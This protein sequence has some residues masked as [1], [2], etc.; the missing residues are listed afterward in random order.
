MAIID[1]F[2]R[3][4]RR[5]P[6]SVAY[7]CGAESWTFDEA[8]ELSCRISHALARAGCGR[9]VKA[10]VLSPND[11][12]AW[13]GVLGIWRAG[14]TWVPLNPTTPP[15][16]LRRVIDA[17]DCEVLFFH[18]STAS[19]VAELAPSLPKVRQYVC[20]DAAAA[21]APSL[22]QWT[23]GL[24]VT[25]PRTR[26]EMDDVVAISSTGGTTGAPKGV[27]NTHRSLS[28]CL[29]HLMMA[30][31]YECDDPVVDLAA[32]PLSHASGVISLAAT[33]RGGTVVFLP[34]AEPTA[35]LDAIERH[36]VTELFLA[37]TVVYRLMETPGLTERDLSSLRYLLY[38]AAPMSA[39]K[40]RRAIELFGP[41]LMEC[42]GQVEAFAG[43]SFMRPDEHFTDGSIAP[44]ARL[45]SCGRPYPLVCVE[46]RDGEGQQV[47]VGESGEVCV[48]G[49]LVMKGYYADPRRTAETVVDGWLHTG[50]IG[51]FDADGYLF[52][53]DRKKDMIISGGVNIYPSEIEQVIWGHPAVQDCAVIGVPHEDWGE[54]VT[55]VVELNPGARPSGEELIAL[56]KKTLGS[57]RAPKHVDFVTALP[58][59]ANG[60]V[61]KR[62]VRQRYWAGRTRQV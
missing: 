25:P 35:I 18:S 16:D 57:I 3:G 59:S 60:K 22:A 10:G 31:H 56:C 42:Y 50:D 30:F 15:A 48:R 5:A 23:H 44:D 51:H 20:L 45:T 39:E 17:F 49:D 19:A 4:R 62:A 40:L 8:G 46:I 24:P 34:G 28:T 32:L 6:G 55:A 53:T 13:I 33:A 2:D 36:Q 52:I 26:Y 47:P 27:M 9:G 11:A 21:G 12:R 43:V 1:F 14:V 41:V 61:L 38:A 7:V 54:A 29:A 58:R 37:P